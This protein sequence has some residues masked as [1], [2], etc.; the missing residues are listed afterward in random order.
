MTFR[1]TIENGRLVLDDGVRLPSG[2]RVDVSVRGASP[3]R[4]TQKS[5]VDALLR[6]ASHAV[7]TGIR[8]LAAEHDHY[9]Y[10][11]PKRK[12]SKPTKAKPKAARKRGGR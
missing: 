3:T 2:T 7:D 12:K 4:K 5:T 1:G 6:L 11:T 8:D 10:G 9:L